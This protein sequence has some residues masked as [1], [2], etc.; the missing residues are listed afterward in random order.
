MLARS[1]TRS[2]VMALTRSHAATVEATHPP[3]SF[4]R[5]S[6]QRR[7]TRLALPLS[8]RTLILGTVAGGVLAACGDG[9]NGDGDQA[10]DDTADPGAT[11]SHM[12]ASFQREDGLL[13][14]CL[15]QWV[16]STQLWLGAA[17]S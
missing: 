5:L 17:T 2:L 13:E 6:P 11:Y 15:A 3:M 9:G 4:Q 14:A 10:A 16:T 12:T 8:R 1:T 7:N